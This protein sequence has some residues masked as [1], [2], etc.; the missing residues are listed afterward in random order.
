MSS[1]V[2]TRVVELAKQGN[3]DAI[4]LILNRQLQPKGINTKVTCKGETLNLVL[5]GTPVPPQAV[6]V[7]VLTKFFKK[8]EICSVSQIKV[9]GKEA[10]EELPEWQQVLKLPTEEETE[11]LAAAQQGKVGAIAEILNR[12]LNPKGFTALVISEP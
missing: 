2:Q 4:A 5:E 11:P 6:F 9:Y 7:K 8:L 12:N 1:S 3:P 10:E